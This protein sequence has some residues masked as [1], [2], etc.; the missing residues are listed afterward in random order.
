IEGHISRE[1]YADYIKIFG[2]ALR[3]RDADLYR[4]WAYKV[5]HSS[6][7]GEL[8]NLKYLVYKKFMDM[9]K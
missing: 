5:S 6:M 8:V 3:E 4:V 2:N 1:E 7:F 9:S